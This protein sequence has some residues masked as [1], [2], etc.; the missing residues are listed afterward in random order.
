MPWM[1]IA[2]GLIAGAVIVAVTS[3]MRLP[4]M[5]RVGALVLT[6]PL[7]S[8]L[9][10]IALWHDQRQMDSI[11]KLARETL[12]LV[13]LGLPFFVPL[14]FAKQW[15]LGFYAAFALGVVLASACIG[16]WFWLGPKLQ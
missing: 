12:V 10:F 8:I 15:G 5:E 9:A 2:K 14:A 3:L 6:L 1:L 11:A 16:L 7:V 13:P 4:K